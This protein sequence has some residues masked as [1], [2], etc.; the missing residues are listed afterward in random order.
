M[1]NNV[2]FSIVS[3]MVGIISGVAG[4]YFGYAMYK[5]NTHHDIKH[6]A[7]EDATTS[8]TLDYIRRAVDD[9][10]LEQRAQR[11]EIADALERLTRVEESAK[12]AHKRLDGLQR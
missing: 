12:Q 11:N 2:L 6:S 3:V 10:K 5:R 8:A 9:I 4:I 1:N 7:A